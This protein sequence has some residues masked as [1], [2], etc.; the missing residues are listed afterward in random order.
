MNRRG[1]TWVSVLGVAIIASCCM[2]FTKELT[3]SNAATSKPS[4]Y[5]AFSQR[6]SKNNRVHHALERVTFGA[7]PEE[8]AQAQKLGLKKWLE[9]Q[10]HPENLRDNPVLADKLRPLEAVR[11]DTRDVYMR[12]PPPQLIA[13][14]VREKQPLPNDPEAHDLLQDLAEQYRSRKDTGAANVSALS[15]VADLAPKT[16]LEQMLPAWQVNALRKGDADEQRRVLASLP[17]SRG[18][19]FAYALRPPE[20]K[21]LLAL[22]PIGLQRKLLLSLAPSQVVLLDMSEAKILRAAYSTHQLEE[23]MIDFWFN[24]FNVFFAKGADRY[25]LPAYERDC[26][27]PH[28]LGKFYDLLLATAESPAMLFYLDNA[29]SAGPDAAGVAPKAAAINKR[30]RGL[31]ENYGRE[32]MELHTLGVNG[33]YTQQDVTNVARCF[34]GWTVTS[35]REGSTF[36]YN[37]RM[38]DKGEKVVLGHLIRAGGGMEDGLKVLSILARAPQTAHHLSYELAQRFVA[39]DPPPSL[40]NRMAATFAKTDGDIR[41]VLKTMVL[42]PEFFSMGAYQA[43]L[44]SPFEMVVSAVR[45][46][47]ADIESGFALTQQLAQLGEPLYQKMEPTGYSNLNSEWISSAALLARMNFALALA[48]NKIPGIKIDESQWTTKGRSAEDIAGTLLIG[49]PSAQT[50]NAIQKAMSDGVRDQLAQSAQVYASQNG[51][52]VA[53]LVLGSPEFQHR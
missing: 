10:L 43:K 49:E 27:R 2:V 28:A 38:H 12:Y 45:A 15:D 3:A 19:D 16:T 51:S 20:R 52:V 7:R 22:A 25:M 36:K 1:A 35:P 21:R 23:E 17:E 4:N 32:L 41:Q 30:K 50:L 44:K 13:A 42:S 8:V 29:Q 24:H 26:I 34:T 6:L 39:D 31:N 33:G 48:S 9:L 37:D 53:G 47:R 14:I 11:L 5:E 18:L 46:T 40:V